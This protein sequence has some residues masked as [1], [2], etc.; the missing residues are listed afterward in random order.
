MASAAVSVARVRAGHPL[1][2]APGLP[3]ELGSMA[4]STVMVPKAGGRV[5]PPRSRAA[6]R[7]MAYATVRRLGWLEAMLA[8]LNNRTVDPMVAALQLVALEQLIKPMRPPAVIVDQAVRSASEQAATR[9]AGGLINAVLRRFLREREPLTARI[10]AN[11][12]AVWNFPAWWISDLKRDYAGSWEQILN[13]S[14]QNAPMTL[15]VNRRR[16]ERDDYLA[17]LEAAGMSA[18]VLGPCALRLASAV[19]VGRLPGFA[20]GLVSVQDAGAQLAARLLD[21][22]DGHR[23]LDACAAPGGKTAHLLENH[24]V[25]LLAL[26]R[27]A[28]RARQIDENLDRLGLAAGARVVVADAADPAAWWDGRPFQRILVDAPCSASGVVRRHPEIRWLRQRR[29]IETFARTQ[30]EILNGLWPT[31]ER[32]GKLLYAT[33]SVFPSE[34]EGVIN[35]F[36]ADRREARRL[37]L[38]GSP[39]ASD[40]WIPIGQLLP[41]AG[42]DRDHDGFFYALIEKLT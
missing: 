23:V 14:A 3:D 9:H 30:C 5:M 7:D 13:I 1:P 4:S 26:D 35:R 6:I 10:S 31:L 24:A 38:M 33:C 11:P 15:R 40:Q 20:D 32:G 29:D 27:D 16:I 12:V 2:V 21:V 17:M 8:Q 25:E 39:G 34:G 28:G 19:D 37:T 41:Q 36:L 22:T 42:S 18:S